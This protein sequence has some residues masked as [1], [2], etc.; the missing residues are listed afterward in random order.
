MSY[1]ERTS[2]TE[3]GNRIMA[4][5]KK[6]FEILAVLVAATGGLVGI[7]VRFHLLP[8][9]ARSNLE[10]VDF[11]CDNS[12][13]YP[14]ITLKL[15]NAGGQTAFLKRVEFSISEASI[16]HDPL[17][18][19]A[20]VEPVTYNVM[21]TTA[22]LAAGKKEQSL[23]RKI[24]P[25]NVDALEFVLGFEELKTKVSG[26]VQLV[27]HFNESQK[28]VTGRLPITIDNFVA[29]Y[30]VPALGT[31]PEAVIDQLLGSEDST[32]QWYAIQKLKTLGN[33]SSAKHVARYLDSRSIEVRRAASDAMT[34]IG[35]A[36]VTPNLV[37]S[38]SDPDEVVRGN[39]IA[40]LKH[41]GGDSVIEIGRFL[42]S[43]DPKGREAALYALAACGGT[44]ASALA[45]EFLSDHAVIRKSFGDSITVAS[46]AARVLGRLGFAENARDLVQLLPSDVTAE[47]REAV[48]SLGMIG[49]EEQLCNIARMLD[50]SAEDVRGSA[51]HS[52]VEAS[53]QGKGWSIKQW[54]RWLDNQHCTKSERP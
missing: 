27:L 6:R 10:I 14:K 9:A 7:M 16:K 19:T 4:D 42:H 15:R 33:K 23:S 44:R 30:P 22:N 1:D 45:V 5:W 40:A 36:A 24:E 31:T 32:T 8:K 3:K 37:N 2:Q 28:I 20:F 11:T 21:L 47:R 17:I 35:D 13:Y 39:A 26:N 48:A 49:A 12:T 50:D 29:R 43:A 46:I 52:L 41:L 38:L 25:D 18:Y 34:V 51:L 54:K 53:G